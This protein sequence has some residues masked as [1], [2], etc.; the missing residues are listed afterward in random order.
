MESGWF[1]FR[2]PPLNKDILFG[3]IRNWSNGESKVLLKLDKEERVKK[4]WQ[5]VL[6]DVINW[7]KISA[8][9]EEGADVLRNAYR[10][11]QILKGK[12]DANGS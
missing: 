9:G 10:K 1:T 6:E 2:M 8:F 12:E 4:R 5:F 11:A 7:H 3:P